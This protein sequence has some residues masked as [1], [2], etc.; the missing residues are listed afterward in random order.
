MTLAPRRRVL[1]VTTTRADY[2]LWRPVHAALARRPGLDVGY[3][4]TGTH[5]DPAHGATV[6]ALEADGAPI[7]ARLPIFEPAP[8]A[9]ADSDP[10]RAARAMA[11]LIDG[12]AGAWPAL[13]PDLALVL[14]DRFEMLAAALAL[15]LFRVPLGHLHGGERTEGALDEAYRHALTKL[16]HLHFAATAEY[17]TRIAQ[18]GEEPW[19]I[20]ATG[21]PALDAIVAAR[22]AGLPHLAAVDGFSLDR[23]FALATYHPETL[24]PAA[25]DRGLAA[26]L[27]A[28]DVLDL[29][30]LFTAP[31]ADPGGDAVRARLDA[32]IAARPGRAHLV[33]SLGIPRYYQALDQAAVLIGNSSSGIL[34][35]P[36]FGLPV[37][38]IGARQQGRVRSVNII[39]TPPD[40]DA[41]TRALRRALDPA[42]RAA[43]RA[44]PHNPHGDG[45]ASERI[46]DVVAA[47]D[48]AR[49][50]LLTK[51]FVD[52]PPRPPEAP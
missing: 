7:W 9:A 44:A 42:W 47:L 15:S 20:H 50:D 29:P 30:T 6:A 17:A 36:S 27:A 37:V 43:L 14:G 5:L 22:A 46:A 13:S 23:P 3:L 19:R 39:D 32:W 18:L 34:E 26:L 40:A 33:P 48:L 11:R 1:L 45:R 49:P 16:S 25:S 35:A 10:A 2:G 28:L 24:D 4:V 52:W 12:V 51:P 41:V 21:A 31:N 8:A 38:N